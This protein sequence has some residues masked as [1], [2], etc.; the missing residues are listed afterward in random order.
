MQATADLRCAE[1]ALEDAKN[2]IKILNQQIANLE[3]RVGQ[4][5]TEVTA[6]EQA[7]NGA[8]NEGKRIGKEMAGAKLEVRYMRG[9][10]YMLVWLCI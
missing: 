6:A 2:E 7:L 8:K 1:S 9:C 10:V 4:L 3:R 5:M